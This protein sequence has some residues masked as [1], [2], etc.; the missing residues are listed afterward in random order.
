MLQDKTG[1]IKS[2]EMIILWRD[3]INKEWNPNKKQRNKTAAEEAIIE[4]NEIEIKNQIVVMKR[5]LE[6]S[7]HQEGKHGN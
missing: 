5:G 6:G 4:D 2:Q 3:Q 7:D 1:E